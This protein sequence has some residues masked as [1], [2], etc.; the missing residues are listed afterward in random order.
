MLP[1]ENKKSEALNDKIESFAFLDT[2]YF[3]PDVAAAIGALSIY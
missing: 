1:F 3:I 2:S